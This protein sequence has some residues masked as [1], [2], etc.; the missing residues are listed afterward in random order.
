[1][2]SKSLPLMFVPHPVAPF[3]IIHLVHSHHYPL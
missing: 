1:M 3:L 2:A